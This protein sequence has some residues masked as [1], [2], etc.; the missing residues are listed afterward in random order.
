MTK[1]PKKD[2]MKID[3]ENI[4][5]EKVRMS[6]IKPSDINKKI[7]QPH[8]EDRI[9]KLSNNIKKNGLM[10]ALIVS[11]DGVIVSGHTRYAALKFRF[12]TLSIIS[13]RRVSWSK[14]YTVFNS[15]NSRQILSVNL[16][17]CLRDT[18][19]GLDRVNDV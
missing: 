5:I 11:R 14:L 18:L 16:S 2:K 10:E 12:M 4:A 17:L 15:S 13:Q 19:T 8:H 7:Y 6:D 3:I 1:Q 9:V